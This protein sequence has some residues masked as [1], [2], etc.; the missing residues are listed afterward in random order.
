MIQLSN[1]TNHIIIGTI[2]HDPTWH[3]LTRPPKLSMHKLFEKWR[4][5]DYPYIN[6]TELIWHLII[7]RGVPWSIQ[8]ATLQ[9]MIPNLNVPPVENQL[10]LSCIYDFYR[11]HHWCA[12]NFDSG[13]PARVNYLLIEGKVRPNR[14]DFWRENPFWKW[15]ITQTTTFDICDV[16]LSGTLVRGLPVRLKTQAWF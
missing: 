6:V 2:E 3:N 9:G 8:E 4:S 10:Y 7:W 11:C 5:M 12:N 16:A 1:L 15:T 14:E 13:W